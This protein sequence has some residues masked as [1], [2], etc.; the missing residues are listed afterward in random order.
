MEVLLRGISVGDI[1][2]FKMPIGFDGLVNEAWFARCP[3]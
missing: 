3:E 1:A 2:V